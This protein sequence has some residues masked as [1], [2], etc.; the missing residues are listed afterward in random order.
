MVVFSTSLILP[1][2][3]NYC[4]IELLK[5]LYETSLEIDKK[6]KDLGF[7]NNIKFINNSFFNVDLSDFD[8]IFMHYPMKNAEE[9]YLKLEDKMKKELKSNSLIISA[10][11]K[12]NDLDNFIF[13]GK[14][15]I[16]ASYGDMTMYYHI[17][18]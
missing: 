7:N 15:T 13:I 4:G 3:D 6:F 12:L 5:S 14:E 11:R 16:H 9:L 18:K 17:K 1:N 8:V 2:Y 10:I